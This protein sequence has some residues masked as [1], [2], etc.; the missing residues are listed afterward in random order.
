MKREEFL[1]LSISEQVDF[2]NSKIKEGNS[3]S[4]IAKDLGI[5]KSIAGKFKKH[6]FILVSLDNKES[7]EQKKIGR[8]RE[9]K[10]AN[11]HTVIMDSSLWKNLKIKSIEE[12]RT[13]SEI[14]EELTRLY[15]SK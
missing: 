1:K 2:F 14:L 11:K 9:N 3:I 5:S 8:P 10:Q 4:Q 7:S 6:G 12:D 15:L 13:A